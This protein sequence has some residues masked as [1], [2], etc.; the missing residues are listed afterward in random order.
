MPDRRHAGFTLIELLVILG[1]IAAL[2]AIALPVY[3]GYM[4]GV[5]ISTVNHHFQ[6]AVR[7]ARNTYS[8]NETA[9]AIGTTA[10]A[11]T[12][13]DG[14]I[15]IF[16]S[17]ESNAPGGG[18]A[19]VPTAIGDPMTGAIGVQAVAGTSDVLVIRPA[20]MGLEP[21]RAEVRSGTVTYVQL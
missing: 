13:A 21:Y 17:G 19:Y 3:S 20:Y 12:T 10:V 6:E 2:T 14:W 16:S 1:V 7:V 18:P 8:R 9:L 15:N 5:R 4:K 11:P